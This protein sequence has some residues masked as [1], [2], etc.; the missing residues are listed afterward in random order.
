MNVELTFRRWQARQLRVAEGKDIFL[1][2]LQVAAV[3]VAQ[4]GCRVAVA[5]AF[6]WLLHANRSVVGSDDELD[7]FV[8]YLLQARGKA[9]NAQTSLRSASDSLPHRWPV[10]S[11]LPSRCGRG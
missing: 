4:V 9:A 11:A 7:A 5:D 2:I 1:L 3:L 10:P 8:S 6:A